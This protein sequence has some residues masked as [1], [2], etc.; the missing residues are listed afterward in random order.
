MITDDPYSDRLSE[1]L[2]DED[3]P[4]HER[5]AIDA[6]LAQCESCRRT[7]DELR[8]VAGRAAALVDTPPSSELWPG[9]A[10]RLDPR[11]RRVFASFRRGTP[12]RRFSFTLPQ[13]VAASLAL[14]I[15]SGGAVWLARHGG[16]QTELPTIAGKTPDEPIAPGFAPASVADAHY[17]EAIADLEKILEEGRS[18]LDPETVRVLQENLRTIDQAIEQCRR[19]LA[20]DPADAYLNDHLADAKR[21]KLALLRRAY[22]LA[23][24]E[25]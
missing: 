18:K 19:A 3:L 7:L 11:P 12:S 8:E 22:A 15:A 9:V 13:L 24:Q 23:D 21:R 17:D 4:A 10:A 1:Y 20:A 2:D 5:A 25:S 16:S 6:H 14:M